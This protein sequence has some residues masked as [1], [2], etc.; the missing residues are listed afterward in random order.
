MAM[1]SGQ[2][3]AWVAVAMGDGPQYALVDK[4]TL[5]IAQ[6]EALKLCSRFTTN[7]SLVDVEWRRGALVVVATGENAWGVGSSSEPSV[8]AHQAKEQGTEGYV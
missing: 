2:A 1:C 7:C 3:D 6:H 4:V 8:A 5:P